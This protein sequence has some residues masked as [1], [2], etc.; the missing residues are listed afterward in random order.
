MDIKALEDIAYAPYEVIAD[1]TREDWMK[2]YQALKTLAEEKPDSGRYPNTLGY[3]CFYGRHTGKPDYT[4]A[5]KWFEKGAALRMIESTYK[6]A[7]MQTE[8]LGGE[9]DLEQALRNYIHVYL[10]CREQLESGM[11]DSKFADTALR[12]GRVFHE[13]QGVSRDDSV[14]L[15]YLLEAQYAISKREFY[16]RYGDARVK[17]N[18]QSL[19]DSCEQPDQETRRRRFHSL[20]PGLVPKRFINDRH[21]LT[22]TI[23][24]SED[25]DTRLVFRRQSKNEEPANNVLWSV[26]PAMSCF[27]TDHIVLYAQNVRLIWTIRPREPVVC[28]RYEYDEK[29]QTHLYYLG[30]EL[31][32]R[33]LGG[34]Y[35][36][37]ME[38]L[39]DSPR[40]GGAP[41]APVS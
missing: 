41:E 28:D 12:L 6:L 13:G 33:L 8:G 15:G 40:S 17:N 20:H 1:P 11:D 37:S 26:P 5:R 9:K 7:D 2:A 27:L 22:F 21:L 18:I 10:F 14:A 31:Q 39:T 19:I 32:C 29:K 30:N 34:R 24:V 16:H 36:L 38:E 23:Q 35:F 4:E 25:G 3:I